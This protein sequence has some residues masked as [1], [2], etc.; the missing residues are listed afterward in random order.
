MPGTSGALAPALR[1]EFPQ[2]QQAVRV[3][4]RWQTW[5]RHEEKGFYL[6]FCVADTNLFEVFDFPLVQGNA[7]NLLRQ[8][9]SV[10]ITESAA[11]RYFGDENPI[12]KIII[13]EN[14][15]LR[16][17]YTIV[18]ILRDLPETTFFRFNFDFL[19]LTMTPINATG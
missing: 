16:A 14:R 13:P 3:L 5:V 8:P 6:N 1:D 12:G 2:V 18:G 11:R 17:D 4:N 10:L 7:Q 19:T 9:Y 15:P